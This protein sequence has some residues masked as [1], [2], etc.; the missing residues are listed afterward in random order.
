MQ[1]GEGEDTDLVAD[2]LFAAGAS[3]VLESEHEGRRE[4]VADLT[5]EMAAGLARPYRVLEPP[6]STS[7]AP[8]PRRAGRHLLLVPEGAPG[9]QQVS[10]EQVVH[11]ARGDAFGAGSHVSTRLCLAALEPLAPSAQSV[12][13]VGSGTGVLGVAAALLGAGSVRSLDIDP[14]A[15]RTTAA[16][17]ACNGVGDVVAVELGTLAAGGPG[18]P[19]DLVLANLLA[20]IV[21]SLADELVAHVAP[22]GHLVVGGLLLGQRARVI[23]ALDG[24]DLEQQYVAGD[25]VTLVLRRAAAGVEAHDEGEE[26]AHGAGRAV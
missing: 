10:A 22:G 13:D 12:L 15:V 16:T 21:E 11:I 26:A 1:L 7:V 17:A 6:A 9:A 2:A 18:S 19:A 24:L 23:A 25:W 8:S 3:A 20:P 4:L 14:E 5:P